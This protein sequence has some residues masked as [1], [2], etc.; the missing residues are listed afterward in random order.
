[1]GYIIRITTKKEFKKEDIAKEETKNES[2][3]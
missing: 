2:H 3:D 1:M